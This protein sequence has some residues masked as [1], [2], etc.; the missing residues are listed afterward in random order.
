LGSRLRRRDSVPG[1]GKGRLPACLSVCLPAAQSSGRFCQVAQA[2][3]FVYKGTMSLEST[4][5]LQPHKGTSISRSSSRATWFVSLVISVWVP[6]SYGSCGWATEKAGPRTTHH[7]LPPLCAP[8][9]TGCLPFWVRKGQSGASEV[10][11]GDS[12]P[13]Q[14]NL[15]PIHAFPFL[16]LLSFQRELGGEVE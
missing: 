4:C 7:A 9:G 10:L 2:T 1:G 5:A 6:A 14:F 15:H 3:I 13:P 12:L 16:S 11:M 8:C